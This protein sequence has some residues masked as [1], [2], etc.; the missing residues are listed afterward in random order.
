MPEQEV[1]HFDINGVC[2]KVLADNES[3]DRCIVELEVN[4]GERVVCKRPC[5]IKLLQTCRWRLEW[6]QV[7]QGW[8]L[9]IIAGDQVD[10]GLF[11]GAVGPVPEAF[12]G[13]FL[14]AHSRSGNL[15]LV[16]YGTIEQ[17][18]EPVVIEAPIMLDHFSVQGLKGTDAQQQV[19]EAWRLN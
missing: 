9:V 11:Q 19:I 1:D 10:P 15:L 6:H 4:L 7:N 18:D 8:V 16:I 12:V 2:L 14:A 5:H 3:V 13:N 17:T